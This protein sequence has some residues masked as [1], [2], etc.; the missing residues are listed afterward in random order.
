MKQFI[1]FSPL[2]LCLVFFMSGCLQRPKPDGLPRL[3]PCVI[4]LTQE[5]TP[6]VGADIQLKAKNGSCPWPVGGKTD[7]DGRAVIVTY[8][9]HKGAPEGTF[10]VSVSLRET[11]ITREKGSPTAAIRHYSLVEESFTQP[12]TT[13]LEIE[14]KT[15]SNTRTFD[16]GKPAKILVETDVVP[17]SSDNP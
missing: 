15:S 3:Y 7:V 16:L 17:V 12:E 11:E 6:L 9:Q 5:G 4:V 14:I 8:G 13:S 10:A 1:S 2:F